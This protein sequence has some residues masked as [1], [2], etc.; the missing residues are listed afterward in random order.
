MHNAA[1]AELGLEWTYVLMP[2]QSGYIEPA[3]KELLAKNF[4]GANVTMPHK[5]AVMP[6]LDELSDAAHLIGAVNT[7]HIGAD[8]VYGENTDANG[9]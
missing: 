9:F 4:V 5:Q 3:L 6:H 8:K 2:V 1:F 7:I